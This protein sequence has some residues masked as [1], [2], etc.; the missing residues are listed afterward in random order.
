MPPHETHTERRVFT[1][2]DFERFAAL[3]R[4]DNPIHVDPA[5]A[6]GTRFGRPVAHG[7]MLY[8]FVRAL[9]GRHFPGAA[10]RSQTLVFPAPTYAGEVVTITARVV[11]RWPEARRARV[12]VT[13]TRPDG[14]L[15]LQGETVLEWG[16]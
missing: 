16:V 15:G 9:L 4:D 13:L 6:A 10:Q 2:A 11:E 12:A 3:S 14:E 5:F 8:G 1:L 7:M